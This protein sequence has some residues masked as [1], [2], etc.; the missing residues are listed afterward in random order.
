MKHPARDTAG[1]AVGDE[2]QLPLQD[3]GPGARS[4]HVRNGPAGPTV[5]AERSA[6]A[7][8]VARL[9]TV[10]LSM[11]A[12][13]VAG[14]RIAYCLAALGL[15]VLA[16]EMLR[17]GAGGVA[18][19]LDRLSVEGGLNVFGFGWLGAY[20]LMSGSPVAAVGLTLFSGGVL[21][22]GEAFAMLN[23][24]RYGASFSVLFVGFLYYLRRRRDPD[25][26]YIGAVALL[27]TF[28]VYVPSMLLGFLALR[29]GWLDGL[30]FGQPVFF[31]SIVSVVYDPAV[32]RASA[33]LPDVALF[34]PGVALLMGSFL[35]FDRALP[36]LDPPGE[37][38]ERLLAALHR[39]WAM[40][41]VGL[42]V[43][44]LTL[45]VSI[46]LTLLVPLSVKGFLRRHSIIPYVMG[47]NISTFGDTLLAATLLGVPR[48][49]T[50]VLVQM[51]SV[52]VV[53]AL[54]LLLAYGPY[55]RAILWA[56]HHAT[57]SRGGFAIFLGVI[58]LA[59]LILLF[60]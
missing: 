22:D 44:A 38:L 46:S 9:P 14:G 11:Q 41:A 57:R 42:L 31:T 58:L 10:P 39:P 29:R 49:V 53:S 1:A 18:P 16:L 48:A 51:L 20:L 4:V 8:G 21:S 12:W 3:G 26:L 32:S 52:A 17:A 5:R 2:S 24:S 59:P 13:A 56:A 40:F 60:L 45:S 54:V 27:T 35:M 6:L 34:V 47:A 50:I 37:R 30:A 25:G 36:Q 28:T 43:T 55:R 33:L 7:G 19:F 23:G 15:F